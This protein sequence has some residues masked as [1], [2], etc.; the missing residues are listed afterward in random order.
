[1]PAIL[2]GAAAAHIG[3][4]DDLW[5]GGVQV[6]RKSPGMVS[7]LDQCVATGGPR[8]SRGVPSAFL[9]AAPTS[10]T[11]Q[12]FLAAPQI[13]LKGKVQTAFPDSK[14]TTQTTGTQQATDKPEHHQENQDT[15]KEG[16]HTV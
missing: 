16:M 9:G 15:K 14:D 2:S 10:V 1:M 12:D 3:G 4:L 6:P 5:A 8:R 13:Q 7:A 11:S